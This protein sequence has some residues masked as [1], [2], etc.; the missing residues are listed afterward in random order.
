VTALVR[1]KNPEFFFEDFIG[2]VHLVQHDFSELCS[3]LVIGVS[4]YLQ[5]SGFIA[6]NV[7]FPPSFLF[8]ILFLLFLAR[9]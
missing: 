5:Q 7:A 8:N 4:G 3:G 2:Q 6:T 1:A 9:G